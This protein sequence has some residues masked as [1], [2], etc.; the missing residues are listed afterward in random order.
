VYHVIKLLLIPNIETSINSSEASAFQ[1]S[2]D[3]KC[4][5]ENILSYVHWVILNY[6][7]PITCHVYVIALL[8]R[9]WELEYCSQY[10][11]RLHANWLDDL[12]C[13]SL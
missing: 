6:L 1:F 13:E 5:Y 10:S 12:G 11:D 2:H 8:S 3:V 7:A 4:M 9:V